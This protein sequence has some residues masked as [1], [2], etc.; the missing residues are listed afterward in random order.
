MAYLI[1]DTETNGL[2][3]NKDHVIEIGGVIAN[4]NQDTR[5]LEYVDSYQS[6]VFLETYLDEKITDLTGITVDLLSTAPKR[7]V[8]QE[9]W[10]TFINKH[11]IT[12][13]L[14]HSLSF[15][16]G[17]LRTNGFLLPEAYELDTLDVAKILMPDSK[18]LNLDYL[19][20]T[21]K[22][23]QYFPLP[24]ALKDLQHH[25]ALFDAFIAAALF[26]FLILRV[27]ESNVS[28][29]F[30]F[31]LE[32]FLKQKINVTE[33]ITPYQATHIQDVFQ[34]NS[35]K[36]D[37]AQN[38][39]KTFERLLEDD[40]V[41][42]KVNQIYTTIKDN[43]N[44]VYSKIILSIWY[45]LLNTSRLGKVSLN[46]SFEKKFYELILNSLGDAQLNF[47]DDYTLYYPEQLIGENKDL[48]TNNVSTLD[49]LDYLELY[50]GLKSPIPDIITNI[51]LEQSKILASLKTISK[52]SYY[53]LDRNNVALEQSDLV[54]SLASLQ[55]TLK[56]SIATLEIKYSRTA[57]EDKILNY[58]KNSI[59][60]ID[61]KDLSFFY[62]DND[63]KVYVA[64]DF[65]LRDYLIQLLNDAKNIYTS[66]T[67]EEYLKFIAL[68]DLKGSENITYGKDLIIPKVNN[69]VDDLKADN[70]HCKVVFIG[71]TSNLKTF[72]I[73]LKAAELDFMDLSNAGSATKIL[74]K[75]EN[76]YNGIAILSYKSIDFL[77][78]FL[79][80]KSEHLE[81]YFYGDIFL[82]LTKSIK[83]L[84]TK[85]ANQFEFDKISSKLYLKFLLHKLN[86]KFDKNVGF[87]NEI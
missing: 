69:I 21:Y 13:I 8:V 29:D 76:G 43:K 25:R 18:A 34:I 55:K 86:T 5:K 59:T 72:P 60:Y 74:S 52:T 63:V 79:H 14:G 51:K 46:G 31:S 32:T 84:N 19:N 70:A 9:E 77:A 28:T 47:N 45:G 7:H 30:I 68:F 26:N 44:L 82:P 80:D 41:I 71:K 62:H 15:D 53:A 16:T 39:S 10:A 3:C 36:Q 23:D 35:L 42:D 54:N 50:N 78:N 75:I 20:S 24:E 48:T 83:D 4:F 40:T 66:L 57:L 37:I 22:L 73:K 65:N 33:H 12:H 1:L 49:M 64:N 67:P 11:Q 2:D 6:L 87:Y 17:F 58:F 56:A 81:F 38:S 61:S 85:G 27:Q